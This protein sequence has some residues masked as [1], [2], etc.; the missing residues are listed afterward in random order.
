[1]LV[2]GALVVLIGVAVTTSRTVRRNR[3]IFQEFGQSSGL[4][5]VIWLYPIPA[6][7]ALI[8]LP[9]V[10]LLAFGVPL[11]IAFFIP[12]IV[13]ANAN[14]KGFEVAGTDRVDP[15][16]GAATHAI[17]VGVLGIIGTLAESGLF[18]VFWSAARASQR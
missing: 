8:P 5:A 9:V 16:Q 6:I 7:L 17:Y 13:I 18:W 10:Q 3:A 15:V 4:A 14:R 12:G 1:M 2:I 11:A